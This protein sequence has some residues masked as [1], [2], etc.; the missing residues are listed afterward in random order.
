MTSIFEQAS[1]LKLRFPFRGNCTT[2]DLW[3]IS[4]ESLDELYGKLHSQ[5]KARPKSLLRKKSD[6]D[7]AV[8][9]L[10]LQIAIVEHI[11]EVKQAETKARKT[12]ADNAAERRHLLA[13][14][15]NKEDEQLKGKSRKELRKMI[16]DLS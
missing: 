6:K 13:V 3:D 9:L 10:D 12:Q 8:E 2:E 7:E 11:V 14:L 5:V 16:A 15:A 1:R 4:L